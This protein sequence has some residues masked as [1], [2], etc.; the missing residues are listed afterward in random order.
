MPHAQEKCTARTKRHVFLKEPNLLICREMSCGETRRLI[1]L[2][3]WHCQRR[4]MLPVFW[5]MNGVTFGMAI[6]ADERELK[7]GPL[8]REDRFDRQQ[9]GRLT[10][11]AGRDAG[12]A[13]HPFSIATLARYAD[14]LGVSGLRLTVRWNASI[15]MHSTPTVLVNQP[16]GLLVIP[17]GQ[18]RRNRGQITKQPSGAMVWSG[19]EVHLCGGCGCCIAVIRADISWTECPDAIDG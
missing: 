9:S 2:P 8:L 7:I 4:G 13:R 1:K 14:N 5:H 6:I 15:W 3:G 16:A 18:L 12:W 19:G 11:S 10:R 17:F